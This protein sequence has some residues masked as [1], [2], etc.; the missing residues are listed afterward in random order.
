[1]NF[2]FEKLNQECL[3]KNHRYFVPWDNITRE[4]CVCY[5]EPFKEFF[6]CR[7]CETTKK[8]FIRVSE[9]INLSAIFKRIDDLEN[10]IKLLKKNSFN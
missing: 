10:E 6:L 1:M 7:K 9:L 3:C 4:Y 5:T 2:I 8:D